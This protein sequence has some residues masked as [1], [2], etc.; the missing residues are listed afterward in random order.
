MKLRLFII[1]ILIAFAFSSCATIISGSN[2][3]VNVMTST[4]ERVDVVASTQ[5]GPVHF[6]APAVMVT[7]ATGQDIIVTVEDKC[8]Q[9]T[10]LIIASKFNFITLGN[11]ITGGTFGFSTDYGTDAMWDYDKNVFVQTY[12][13][14]ECNPAK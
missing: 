13:K 12:K 4:G 6:S 9:Q 8:Y 10:Q 2:R 5:A 7:P 14:P 11:L 3:N 1:L